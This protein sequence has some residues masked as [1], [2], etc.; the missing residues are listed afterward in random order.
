MGRR[1]RAWIARGAAAVVA[2]ASLGCGPPPAGLPAGR[3]VDLSH[4]FDADTIFWPTESGF[5]L[6]TG[7]AGRTQQGYWYAANRF[8][9]AEHGGTHVDAPIHFGEGRRSVDELP[10]EQ[11]VGAALLVDVSARCGDDPEC[12][13]SRDDL[14]AFERAHG[15]IPDDAIVLLRTG[16]GARW[17]D[18]ARYLGT[19]ERG[20]QAVPELRFPGL[21]PEAA[22]LLSGERRVRAVGIDTASIDRGSSVLFESHQILAAHDIPAFENLARLDELPPTGFSVIALP[23]KI[24]GGTGGPLRAV[25]LVPED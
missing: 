5:A 12:L 4:P 23:M 11:L 7:F 18:R 13:V 25:A 1:R 17:P 6:E 2:M 22:R 20:A 10:L 3:L 15:R 14:A 8:R 19:A 21:D 24:R 9:T 16:W